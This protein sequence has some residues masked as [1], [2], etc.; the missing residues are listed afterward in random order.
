MLKNTLFHRVRGQQT[1]QSIKW[2]LI[3]KKQK[4][5]ESQWPTRCG[6]CMVTCILS[7]IMQKRTA[8]IAFKCKSLTVILNMETSGSLV[9]NLKSKRMNSFTC[10]VP[11][12]LKGP[13]INAHLFCGVYISVIITVKICIM[14]KILSGWGFRSWLGWK[15]RSGNWLTENLCSLCKSCLK[16][17]FLSSWRK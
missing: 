17:D 7:H 9:R 10:L 6:S 15:G 4:Q 8:L 13:N 16:L 3:K 14:V 1:K 2:E 12:P 11:L 5:K